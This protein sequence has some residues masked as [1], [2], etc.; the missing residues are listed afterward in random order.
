MIE[1]RPAFEA[2]WQ[3]LARRPAAARAAA[4]DDALLPPGAK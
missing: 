1:K 4:I 3:R 2:Y